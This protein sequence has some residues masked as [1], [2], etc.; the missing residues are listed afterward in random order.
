MKASDFELAFDRV[1]GVEKHYA[2]DHAGLTIWGIAEG[3]NPHWK[4]FPLAKKIIAKE[5]PEG[6]LKHPELLDRAKGF[7]RVTFWDF[8]H[9]ESLPSHLVAGKLFS[10]AVN[11][12]PDDSALAAQRTINSHW[13]DRASHVKVD[14]NMGPVTARNLRILLEMRSETSVWNNVVRYQVE[15]YYKKVRAKPRLGKNLKGWLYRAFL[16][17]PRE[18]RNYRRK[19]T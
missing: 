13:E 16:H 5:G 12:G 15:G 4:G 2:V 19:E 18:A 17:K 11:M 7:Y 8:Q 6:L 9:L 10:M 14:G 3:R 1:I